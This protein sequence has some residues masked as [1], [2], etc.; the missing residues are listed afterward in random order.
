MW[1]EYLVE[2]M[3]NQG[4]RGNAGYRYHWYSSSPPPFGPYSKPETVFLTLML[5]EKS[6]K[7]R[8]RVL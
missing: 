5:K 7:I 8:D 2:T 1:N 4:R 6:H 3:N